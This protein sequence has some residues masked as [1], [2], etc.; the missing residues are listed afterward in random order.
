[1]IEFDQFNLDERNAQWNKIADEHDYLDADFQHIMYQLVEPVGRIDR[2]SWMR[3]TAVK[4]L[5]Q[6]KL[7]G[8]DKVG[9]SIGSDLGQLKDYLIPRT[10]HYFEKREPGP[11]D[12]KS[13]AFDFVIVVDMQSLFDSPEEMSVLAKQVA[14]VLKPGG[15]AL[16]LT[17]VILN[18]HFSR[19]AINRQ[20][21]QNHLVEPHN[22][23]LLNGGRIDFRLTLENMKHVCDLSEP[24]PI[25]SLIQKRGSAA[26]TPIQLVF[27]KPMD[28]V[29]LGFDKI[30]LE[31]LGLPNGPTGSSSNFLQQA[32]RRHTDLREWNVVR[33]K[34]ELED[35]GWF[36]LLEPRGPGQIQRLEKHLLDSPWLVDQVKRCHCTLLFSF[37]SEP[38]GYDIFECFDRLTKKH[39]LP[40]TQLVLLTS[41]LSADLKKDLMNE[42]PTITYNF[43]AAEA[44]QWM[45]NPDGFNHR[46]TFEKRPYLY[47]H[48]SQSMFFHQVL[49]NCLLEDKNLITPAL[50][51]CPKWDKHS[52]MRNFRS[53]LLEASESKKFQLIKSELLEGFSHLQERLPLSTTADKEPTGHEFNHDPRKYSES[54][55]S[56]ISD[57]V[58]FGDCDIQEKTIFENQIFF[59]PMAYKAFLNL[60]PMIYVG[61]A[62]S[63]FHLRRMGFHMFDDFFD[64]SYDLIDDPVQRLRSIAN[65]VR[66]LSQLNPDQW[67]DFYRQNGQRLQ[68]NQRLMAK[69]QEHESCTQWLQRLGNLKG[70][71]LQYRS[72]PLSRIPEPEIVPE[73]PNI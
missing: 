14:R 41:D 52:R 23:D 57:R 12:F 34:K 58:F 18:G 38:L 9:L 21:I 70:A 25:F 22:M 68:E 56:L 19:T 20:Q 72:E 65:E 60:H 63:I 44:S 24:H 55:F 26:Q 64:H 53:L 3:V 11:L 29:N 6:L 46:I 36:Y 69:M 28:K 66:R 40:R 37:I 13:H 32:L 62:R 50:V 33:H 45:V 1:M 71:K 4:T 27:K 43:G 42:Y 48:E 16:F 51:D 39:A 47:I 10:K 54:Y 61:P 73:N 59:S 17:D 31:K 49:L 8:P 2:L 35:R 15:H 30:S 7:F 5:Q 67:A